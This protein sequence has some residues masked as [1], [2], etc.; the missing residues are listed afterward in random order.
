MNRWFRTLGTVTYGRPRGTPPLG[1]ARFIVIPLLVT[2]SLLPGCDDPTTLP[3]AIELD[4][5]LSWTQPPPTLRAR[6]KP[7]PC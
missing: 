7:K 5:K 4:A 6:A 2:I 1:L 3:P